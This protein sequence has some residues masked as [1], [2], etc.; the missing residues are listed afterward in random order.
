MDVLQY[1]LATEKAIRML[2]A[3]NVVTFIVDK[4]SVSRAIKNEFEK[5][6]NSKV[7][8]IRIIM[9]TAGRKKAYIKLKPESPAIDVATKLGIM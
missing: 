4:R 5:R 3:D 8:T 1:P 2:E 7:K 6:F 9:D